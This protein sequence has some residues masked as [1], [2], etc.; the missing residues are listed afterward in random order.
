MTAETLAHI[1]AQLFNDRLIGVGDATA[2]PPG[3]SRV[4]L[5]AHALLCGLHPKPG[6]VKMFAAVV[7]VS[8]RPCAGCLQ[9]LTC[10]KALHPI[11]AAC[12]REGAAGLKRTPADQSHAA[13]LEELELAAFGAVEGALRTSGVQAQEVSARALP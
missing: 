1:Q 2:V 3:C 12:A 9:N 10:C 6:T 11:M 4:K 5:H 13:A 8:C 7:F